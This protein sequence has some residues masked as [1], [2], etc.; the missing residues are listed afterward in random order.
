MVCTG[1]RVSSLEITGRNIAATIYGSRSQAVTEMIDTSGT[2]HIVFLIRS[3]RAF[4]L[5]YLLRIGC[6]SQ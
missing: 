1:A 3:D 4:T 6:W 5:K 2:V